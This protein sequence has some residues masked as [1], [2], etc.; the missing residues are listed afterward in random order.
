MGL[1][2]TFW[3]FWEPRSNMSFGPFSSH[4]PILAWFPNLIRSDEVELFYGKLILS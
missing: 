1:A 3:S 2:W 4:F